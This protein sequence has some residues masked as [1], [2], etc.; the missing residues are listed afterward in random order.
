MSYFSCF[1]FFIL[2]DTLTLNPFR[3][4]NLVELYSE[5]RGWLWP[6]RV[7]ICNGLKRSARRGRE[8]LIR[9]M[10]DCFCT[11]PI[12]TWDSIVSFYSANNI[13]MTAYTHVWF[14]VRIIQRNLNRFLMEQVLCMG[15]HP[16]GSI[17]PVLCVCVCTRSR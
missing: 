13:Y 16:A 8:R 14:S 15:A 4:W 7:S 3:I 11:V 10:G 17:V 1:F 12:Y 9:I 6:L 2:C 5:A